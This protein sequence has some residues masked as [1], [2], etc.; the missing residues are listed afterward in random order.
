VMDLFRCILDPRRL[1][2][3]SPAAFGAVEVAGSELFIWFH[4][5]QRSVY[6]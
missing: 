6:R 3:E 5:I 2:L 4:E 1:G